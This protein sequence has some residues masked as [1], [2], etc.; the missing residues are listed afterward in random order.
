MKV[1][2]SLV[3]VFSFL[4]AGSIDINSASKNELM[5]LN[6]VGA[7]KADAIVMYRKK[8]CFKKIADLKNV[9]GIGA[10]FIEKNKKNIRAGKCKK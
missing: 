7:K 10:K 1:L 9:K 4:F 3:M 8:H 6:G 2:I 5:S